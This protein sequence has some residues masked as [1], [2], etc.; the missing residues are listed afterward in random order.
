MLRVADRFHYRLVHHCVV[1][2]LPMRLFLLHLFGLKLGTLEYAENTIKNTILQCIKS[3]SLHPTLV[4]EQ[5]Y[6]FSIVRA[7]LQRV[8][9]VAITAKSQVYARLIQPGLHAKTVQEFQY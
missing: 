6:K 4:Q 8:N 7:A 9:Q 5:R 3:Q 2:A 1:T